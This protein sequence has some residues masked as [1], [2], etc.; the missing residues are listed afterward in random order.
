MLRVQRVNQT[1]LLIKSN[2]FKRSLTVQVSLE[3][4]P[5]TP[6]TL[7]K[8]YWNG[9]Q[10]LL[11][12]C[13]SVSRNAVQVLLESVSK[14]YRNTHAKLRQGALA[15]DWDF[16]KTSSVIVLQ[17]SVAGVLAKNSKSKLRFEVKQFYPI[18]TV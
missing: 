16:V 2:Y 12:S 15:C 10:V 8:C 7:S 13:S 17:V 1:P 3:R 5:S 18:E 6:G 9:V 11:E 14:C 4:C